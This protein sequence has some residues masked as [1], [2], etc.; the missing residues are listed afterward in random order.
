MLG[1]KPAITNQNYEKKEQD[2]KTNAACSIYL[3]CYGWT[4]KCF[5]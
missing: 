4:C 2:K 5:C 1:T 3:S